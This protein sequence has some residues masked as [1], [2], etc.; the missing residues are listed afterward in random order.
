M[1]SL[2]QYS[3]WKRSRLSEKHAFGI[4]SPWNLDTRFCHFNVLW[5]NDDVIKWK[6]FPR[7]W[8]FVRVI[9]RSPVNSPHK[10]PVT[11]YFDFSLIYFWIR[12]WVNSG[13]AG[14]LWRHRAHYD[15]TVITLR[16]LP[17]M[18]NQVNSCEVGLL[19]S[20]AIC[21]WLKSRRKVLWR[22]L[23][24]SPPGQNG[25]HFT[26]DIFRSF[27]VNDNFFILWLKFHW[28]LFLRIELIKSQHGFR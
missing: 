4:Y 9:H 18:N 14:D 2:K 21:H 23:N 28:S 12:G 25:R 1:A 16:N 27:F 13:E 7:Y 22:Q 10:R 11:R 24:P 3:H 19:R 15:F 6:H 20:Q 17:S 5:D 26:D 8:P